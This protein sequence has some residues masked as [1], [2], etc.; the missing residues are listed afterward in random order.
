MT[1]IYAMQEEIA[2]LLADKET[3]LA[4]IE[5]LTNTLAAANA[6]IEQLTRL[7]EGLNSMLFKS[8]SEQVK[9]VRS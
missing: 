9:A 2:I 5:R 6:R 3:C 8:L 7:V 1:K 4:E